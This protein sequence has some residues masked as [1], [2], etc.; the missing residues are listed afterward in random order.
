ML[1][2]FREHH[3]TNHA[4]ITSVEIVTKVL[5]TVKY[6]VNVFLDPKKTFYMADHSI[7]LNNV[8]IWN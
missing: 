3:S 8:N 6:V 4:I 2:C 5:D 7:L 1:V